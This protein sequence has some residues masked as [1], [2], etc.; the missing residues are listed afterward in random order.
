M[1]EGLRVARAHVVDAPL[2]R[3]EAALLVAVQRVEE[4]LAQRRVSVKEDR[5][6][7]EAIVLNQYPSST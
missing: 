4:V 5:P 6:R 3:V 7:G 2:V 1:A